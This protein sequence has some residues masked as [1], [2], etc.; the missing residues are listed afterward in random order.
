M[1]LY[2][3][4]GRYTAEAIA[5]QIRNPQDRIEI[6][7]PGVERAGG[8]IVAYGYMTAA[9]GLAVIVDYP[10]DLTGQVSGLSVLAGGA[11]AD[12]TTVR[13]LT[14]EEWVQLLTASQGPAD[15]YIPP[16]QT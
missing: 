6:L 9:P 8:R 2:L 10:D 15:G 1:T 4:Q 7:R 16:G 13:L 12:V 5:A 11:F 14:G 3:S